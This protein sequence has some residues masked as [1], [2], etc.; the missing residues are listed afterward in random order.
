MLIINGVM[1]SKFI[2]GSTNLHIR[3]GVVILPNGNILFAMSKSEVNFYDFAT[4]FL[5][6]VCKNAL[7]LDGYVSRTCLP[8]K[9]W[10]QE[11]GQFGVIIGVTKAINLNNEN[12][13]ETD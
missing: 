6:N 11:D 3:N 12:E 13:Y 4:L 10:V 1:H 9:N 7:Y 5:D 8:A 2:D